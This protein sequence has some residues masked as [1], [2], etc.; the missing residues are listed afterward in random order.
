MT[1]LKKSS[2]S[3]VI[4]LTIPWAFA[5]IDATGRAHIG[6]VSRFQELAEEASV[7]CGSVTMGHRRQG[8]VLHRPAGWME[9]RQDCTRG[10]GR[11]L[12]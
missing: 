9:Q 3:L 1:L 7:T 11:W 4:F 5:A 10:C 8:V 2:L 12:P 6:D